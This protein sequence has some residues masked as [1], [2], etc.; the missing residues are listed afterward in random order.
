MSFLLELIHTVEPLGIVDQLL[1]ILHLFLELLEEPGGFLVEVGF[2]KEFEVLHK[3]NI[4][5]EVF[6]ILLKLISISLS[7]LDVLFQ[8]VANHLELV[9]HHVVHVHL[10]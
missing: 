8:L 4:F 1:R 10:T 6:N 2:G 7:L 5:W 9:L 3:L